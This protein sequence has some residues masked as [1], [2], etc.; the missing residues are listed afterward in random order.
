M[1][2]EEQDDMHV[3]LMRSE[4]FEPSAACDEVLP[5]MLAPVDR[6]PAWP[7]QASQLEDMLR[8]FAPSGRGVRNRADAARHGK[9]CGCFVKDTG[10]IPPEKKFAVRLSCS[11]AHI[12]I[13]FTDDDD[14]IDG[15]MQVHQCI[16]RFGKG[17]ARKLGFYHFRGGSE[18]AGVVEEHLVVAGRKT[19]PFT[20]VCVV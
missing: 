20:F 9:R 7:V 4:D 18:E 2:P 6:G 1:S 17:V 15:I 13:C 19:D 3:R 10:L 8:A 14:N 5:E 16:K 11:Q 12:G